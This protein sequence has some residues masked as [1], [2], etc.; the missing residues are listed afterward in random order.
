MASKKMTV[1]TKMIGLPIFDALHEFSGSDQL[2]AVRERIIESHGGSIEKIR[3]YKDKVEPTTILRD[4]GVKL[5]DLRLVD[6]SKMEIT[7]YYDFEPHDSAC[8]IL[9]VH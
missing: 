9:N 1:Y 6:P 2:F 4:V 7:I 8:P 5:K 3:L